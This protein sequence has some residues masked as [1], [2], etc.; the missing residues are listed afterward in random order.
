MEA[1]SVG[2]PES[3][4]AQPWVAQVEHQAAVCLHGPLP[5]RRV[6]LRRLLDDQRKRFRDRWLHRLPGFG[7]NAYEPVNGVG[8]RDRSS[9]CPARVVRSVV[10]GQVDGHQLHAR[11][12]SQALISLADVRAISQCWQ[13]R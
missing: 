2:K 11:D 8:G 13:G 6:H 9:R 10:G 3:E 12:L 7:Q 5:R 1:L 4:P